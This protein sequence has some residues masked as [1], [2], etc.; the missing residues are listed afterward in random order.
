MTLAEMEKLLKWLD[1]H[2]HPVV[3]Q[4]PRAIAEKAAQVWG[5]P[6]KLAP[7]GAQNIGR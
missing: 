3:V 5:L 4:L 2:A 1:P 6:A 7:E